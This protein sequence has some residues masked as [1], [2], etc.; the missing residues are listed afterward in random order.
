MIHSP[1]PNLESVW[2]EMEILYEKGLV[3]A[4]GV[5]N[6]AT[7]DLD[8]IMSF[9]RVRPVYI[10]N[11]FKVYKPG[12]QIMESASSI[13]KMAKHYH[14]QMVGYTTQSYILI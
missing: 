5:S 4:L 1:G 10:Q 12:E 14:L 13:K 2:R 9:A 3:R 7:K 8:R 6:V 11:I